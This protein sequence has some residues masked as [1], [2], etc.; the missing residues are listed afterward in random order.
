MAKDGGIARALRDGDCDSI[1][2]TG[3]VCML[4]IG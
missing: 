1:V 2:E 3:A 4:L